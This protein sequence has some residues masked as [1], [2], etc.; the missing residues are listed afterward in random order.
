MSMRVGCECICCSVLAGW[1]IG[2]VCGMY[3]GVLGAANGDWGFVL[4]VFGPGAFGE[5]G[6]ASACRRG[7]Q[8]GYGLVDIQHQA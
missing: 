8:S 6:D 3:S 7:R 5:V 2:E 4:G 1:F